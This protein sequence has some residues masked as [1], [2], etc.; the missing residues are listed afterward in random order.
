MVGDAGLIMTTNWLPGRC[1]LLNPNYIESPGKQP[2]G[3]TRAPIDKE[4]IEIEES[5]TTPK[6]TQGMYTTSSAT[7]P[8]YPDSYT[9][10]FQARV[11]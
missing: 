3:P 2:V 7:G 5:P 1:T 4:V 11:R 9:T 6:P 8:R 10:Q